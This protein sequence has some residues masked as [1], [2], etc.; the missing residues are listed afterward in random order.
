MKLVVRFRYVW[1]QSFSHK[2]LRYIQHG[3]MGG[4]F[5]SHDARCSAVVV[6]LTVLWSIDYYWGSEFNCSRSRFYELSCG[7]IVSDFSDRIVGGFVSVPIPTGID[8]LPCLAPILIIRPKQILAYSIYSPVASGLHLALHATM[9]VTW[10]AGTLVTYG[11]LKSEKRATKGGRCGA[12]I[13][14]SLI[15][16]L[17]LCLCMARP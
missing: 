1:F 11:L 3:D 9:V 10:K 2:S 12:K 16:K 17:Y 4:K 13:K 8:I 6:A 15:S 5:N 14:L 7:L